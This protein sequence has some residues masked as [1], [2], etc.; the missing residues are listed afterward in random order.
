MK[1]RIF[2]LFLSALLVLP[3]VALADPKVTLSS[4]SEKEVV[5]VVD[6][7]QVVKR[8]ATTTTDSGTKLFF[9][10]TYHNEGDESAHNVT[11]DNPVPNGAYYV[12]GSAKGEGTNITF[13]IDK[14]K[15]Y[16]KPS[17]LTYEINTPQGVK[18]KRTAS[19][20]QYSHVRWKISEIEP[21]VKGQ[22]EYQ[23]HVR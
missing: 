10:I 16:K 8:V 12:S 22:L 2:Y 5:E 15:T 1:N 3:V 4:I 18:E 7:K 9:I 6:G 11:F 23:V 13:S 20:E 17:L 21:G 19:P 14:G